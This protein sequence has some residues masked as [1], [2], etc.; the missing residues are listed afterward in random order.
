MKSGLVPFFSEPSS[1]NWDTQRI[2]PPGTSETDELH[3]APPPLSSSPEGEGNSLAESSFLATQSTSAGPS[4]WATPTSTRM[5]LPME[6]TRE[7]ST[8]E[9]RERE[10]ERE[11]REVGLGERKQ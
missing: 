8:W 9:R 10:R 3:R 5:P 1:V 11:K 2:S 6:E 7:P 4:P